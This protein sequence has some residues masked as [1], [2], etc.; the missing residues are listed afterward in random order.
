MFDLAMIEDKV[1]APQAGPLAD[2]R[3]LCRLKMCEPERGQIGPVR[4]ETGQGVDQTH[5][6]IANEAQTL[7]YQDEI[8]IIGHKAAGGAEM[9]NIACAGTGFAKGVNVCH[10]I[11]AE[12]ALQHLGST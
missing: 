10:H 8:G 2:G 11:M 3:E 5:Q 12:L 9:E 7:A 4:R 6:S 1:I